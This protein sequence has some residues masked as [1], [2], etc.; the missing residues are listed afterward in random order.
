MSRAIRHV[1]AEYRDIVKLIE[2]LTGSKS[3]WNVWSDII[4]M[5]AIS[6]ANSVDHSPRSKGREEHYLRIAKGYTAKDMEVIAKVFAEI[7]NHYEACPD[8]DLLGEI[9]MSLNFGSDALGQVFTP[10]HV[11]KMMAKMTV[12]NSTIDD[13]IAERGYVMANDPAC[14]AGATL[15]ALANELRKNNVNYQEKVFIIA[16]DIERTAALMCYIQLSMLGC[17]AAIFIG[18]TIRHPA[19]DNPTRLELDE[20]EQ[21]INEKTRVFGDYDHAGIFAYVLELLPPTRP[22]EIPDLEGMFKRAAREDP[23]GYCPMFDFCI[24]PDCMDCIIDRW[25]R[26]VE[27]E[28]E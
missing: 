5:V 24:R 9:H 18:D 7:V 2:S 16:Q 28:T 19:T 20:N 15:I 1:K 14:G 26:E 8:Q 23:D 22:S 17:A 6:I 10:Y 13:K 3:M 12:G 11:C 21:P 25:R 4:E 27:E